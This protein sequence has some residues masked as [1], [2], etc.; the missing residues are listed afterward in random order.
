MLPVR[1]RASAVDDL[2]KIVDYISQFNPDAAQAMRDRFESCVL[3]LSEHPYLFR[4]G[5]VSGTRE[6]VAHPNYIVVYR[7]LDDQIEVVG[8]RHTSRPYP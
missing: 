8:V 6:I 1:W 3:P 2:D 4:P 7:V 5:R